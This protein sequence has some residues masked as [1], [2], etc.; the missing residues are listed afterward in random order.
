MLEDDKLLGETIYDLLID[1]NYHVDWAKDGKEALELSFHHQYALYLFDVNVP[2]LDGFELLKRLRDAHDVTPTLFMSARVDMQSI[3]QGFKVGA[4]DYIKKPF[5][6]EELLI[7]INAKLENSVSDK[8]N[9]FK[10]AIESTKDG[11][12]DWNIQ[13]N[14]I[15][16]SPKWKSLLGFTEDEIKAELREWHQRIHPDDL[17][18]AIREIQSH[19]KGKK[20]YY[21]NEYRMR[22][23]NGH[24][25]W[26]LDRGKALFDHKQKPYRMVGSYTDITQT[27]KVRKKLQK[28]IDTQQTL[29]ILTDGRTISY[30]NKAFL[31][32]FGYA[33]IDAFSDHHTSIAEKFIAQEHFFHLDNVTHWIEQ[34]LLL[35]GRRRIVSMLDKYN[36]PHAFSVAINPYEEEVYVVSFS[37]ISDT[38][39]EH[40]ELT[41]EAT[42]DPLTNVYNRIYFNKH[43][44]QILENNHTNNIKT[45][46]IIFDIDKFKLVN[47]TYGHDIGDNI[48]KQVTSLVKQHTRD[49]DKIIRWGG[50]E[51]IIIVHIDQESVICSISE[52]LRSVIEENNFDTVDQITCSFGGAVHTMEHDILA[53]IK[54]ADKRLY[55]AKNSGRNKVI[56]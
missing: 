30:A 35:S 5:Y 26:I 44:H 17:E 32:F 10:L 28:L 14:E 31:N 40:M 21:E 54:E 43:I 3:S 2:F 22:H 52:H 50:E 34:I 4:F 9:R 46:I 47:D 53:T 39:V 41:K 37:D 56:C 23:K 11:L 12:W 20:S 15:Y 51:F 1:E 24:W 13:T 6:P 19:L 16:F 45:G 48:L 29:V 25:I 7:R 42:V 33:T 38:M 49:D 8:Q 55:Q 36:S 27:R 18:H